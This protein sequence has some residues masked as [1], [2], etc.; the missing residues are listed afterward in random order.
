MDNKFLLDVLCKNLTEVESVLNH[1]KYLTYTWNYILKH[2]NNAGVHPI[3]DIWLAFDR[4]RSKVTITAQVYMLQKI[5]SLL[6]HFFPQI[7]CVLTRTN[8][9]QNILEPTASFYALN[10][11]VLQQAFCRKLG[12][13]CLS[14][15]PK[16]SVYYNRKFWGSKTLNS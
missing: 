3:L 13:Y 7:Q 2:G 4:P 5:W 14:F 10:A 15:C 12:G 8:I 1:E 11:I 6:P 9:L 16:C